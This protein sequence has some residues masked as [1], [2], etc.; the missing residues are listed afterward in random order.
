VRKRSETAEREEFLM[1]PLLHNLR[2]VDAG[3][4]RE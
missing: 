3:K 4:E 1:I 2:I